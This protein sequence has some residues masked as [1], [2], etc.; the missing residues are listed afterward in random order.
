[1]AGWGGVALGVQNDVFASSLL[2]LNLGKSAHYFAVNL[3]FYA[4]FQPYLSP[5]P[6]T[7]NAAEGGACCGGSVWGSRLSTAQG[8]EL[9]CCNGNHPLPCRLL[10]LSFQFPHQG[11]GCV[12]YHFRLQSIQFFQPTLKGFR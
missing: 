10:H 11:F 7:Q 6:Q 8:S 1:M 3:A 9:R 5:T 2:W 4:V 12:R